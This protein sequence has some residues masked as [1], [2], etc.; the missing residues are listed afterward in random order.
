MPFLGRI[1]GISEFLNSPTWFAELSGNLHPVVL[2]L[3]IGILSLVVLMEVSGWLSFGRY[4]PRTGLPLG[5][6]FVTGVFAC[7][8]GFLDMQID[9]MTQEVWVDHMWAGIAFAVVLGFAALAKLWSVRVQ[10]KKAVYPVLLLAATGVMGYGAHLAGE[11]V[12]GKL[13]PASAP[14]WMPG[15]AEKREKA[16]VV[17]T[18]VT[19]ELLAF[20]QV[21][22]PIMDEKCL[23]CHSEEA[24]K[25][26]GGLLMDTYAN[27][28]KGGDSQFEDEF[29]TLVPGDAA[30][31][32]MI[33]VM[34]LPLDDDLRM[35]PPK[36]DQMAPGETEILTWWVNSIPASPVLEDRTLAEMGAPPEIL[37]YARTI[38][39]AKA[40]EGN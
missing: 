9:G 31:S 6:A 34:S 24:G 29:R 27:L 1:E 11:E 16:A 22:L 5:V 7:L 30:K 33:E 21:V 19:G 35:P 32:Y 3:P 17:V 26:K 36:K 28:L 14:E 25:D 20:E 13:V 12:H 23:Y 4:Q 38:L 10:L 39:E 8:S 18:D 37:E 2:H 40:S 15:R